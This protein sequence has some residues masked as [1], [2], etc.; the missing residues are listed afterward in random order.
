MGG[1]PVGLLLALLLARTGTRV[2][3]LERRRER[4]RGSRS[5]GVHPPALEALARGGVVDAFLEAGVRVRGGRAFDG[6]RPLGRVS[7]ASC[8]PPFP[9][10]LTLPQAVSEA[11]LE[12]AIGR[13][14]PGAVRRGAEV[15][16]VTRAGRGVRLELAGGGSVLAAVLVGCDGHRSVVRAALGCGWRGRRHRDRFVMGDFPD[17]TDLGDD[18]GIYLTGAGVVE[19]FPLP[20][21]LRRWVAAAGDG[22]RPA[23]AEDAASAVAGAVR[24][25]LGVALEPSAAVEATAFGVESLRATRFVGDRIALAGD[26]AHVVPPFGGQGMNLGWLDAEAL[27]DALA[28]VR[29]V[30]GDLRGAPDVALS[31]ALRSYE[32]ARMAAARD[33]ARRAELNLRLGRAWA[34]PAA[35]AALVRLALATPASALLAR[36]FTMRGLEGPRSSPPSPAA[37]GAA[38]AS[39]GSPGAGA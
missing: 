37:G 21:G 30:H 20:G 25:R 10:V 38:H 35:R 22:P 39:P 16:G 27:F 5:I 18:A 4:G 8:P 9:F 7:F 26:A 29:R 24:A 32:R 6:L 15:V 19:S 31:G 2:T 17:D 1:G 33:A 3:V 28:R 13:T 34:V 11:L 36:R 14:A 23:V 12:A